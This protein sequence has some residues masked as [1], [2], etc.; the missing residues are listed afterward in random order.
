MQSLSNDGGSAGSYRR[1]LFWMSPVICIRTTRPERTGTEP[2]GSSCSNTTVVGQGFDYSWRAL[3][4]RIAPT[5]SS[6]DTATPGTRGN[7]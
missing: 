3:K 2:V 7:Q 1:S 5:R 4:M 6:A